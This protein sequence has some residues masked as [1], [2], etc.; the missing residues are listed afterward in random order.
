[1]F[2]SDKC[3]SHLVKR[4]HGMWAGDWSSITNL[5]LDITNMLLI[6]LLMVVKYY[7]MFYLIDLYIFVFC[8]IYSVFVHRKGL[9][10]VLKDLATF[11]VGN[12]CLFVFLLD[13]TDLSTRAY[14]VNTFEVCSGFFWLESTDCIWENNIHCFGIVLSLFSEFVHC[15]KT[16]VNLCCFQVTAKN[17]K[18]RFWIDIWRVG[19]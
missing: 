3:I 17:F 16:S 12:V 15:D 7:F 2:S 11:F 13:F 1:M 14:F 6:A 18:R 10:T 19:W 4:T 9:S 5:V 8:V